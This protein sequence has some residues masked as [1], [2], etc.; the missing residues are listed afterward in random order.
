MLPTRSPFDKPIGERA[1]GRG[2]SGENIE[3]IFDSTVSSYNFFSCSF[4]H[5]AALSIIVVPAVLFQLLL[6]FRCSCCSYCCCSCCSC[7]SYCCRCWRCR[8]KLFSRC[9][10]FFIFKP[11][12]ISLPFFS[13]FFPGFRL[14]LPCLLLPAR[15]PPRP[16]LEPPLA[17]PSRRLRAAL[18]HA[19]SR[20]LAELALGGGG[21]RA[22]GP[23][24]AGGAGLVRERAG[25]AAKGDIRRRTRRRRG[26]IN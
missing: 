21:G 8:C 14:L 10:F 6:L 20:P 1:A 11:F 18:A 9:F 4:S 3:K 25:G 12:L 2:G 23:Q 17:P 26:E 19:Q 13:F 5:A 22:V 15:V 7:C 16:V 24:G